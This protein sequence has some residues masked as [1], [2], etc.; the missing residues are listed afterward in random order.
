MFVDYADNE[1]GAIYKLVDQWKVAVPLHP[2]A[3][4]EPNV[5]YVP[6]IGPSR[7]NDDMSIDEEKPR[8]PSE[9]LESLFGDGVHDALATLKSEME[10]VR[11]GG[12]SEILTMLIAYRWHE[13]LGPFTTDPVDAGLADN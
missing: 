6:P 11:S 9:Y 5:F 12:Q 1:D 4:T 10:T 7:L 13:L 2:E 8:I 3:G